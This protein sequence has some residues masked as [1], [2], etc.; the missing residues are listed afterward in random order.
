MYV[1]RF[2]VVAPLPQ[3]VP[4]AYAMAPRT[5][6]TLASRFTNPQPPAQNGTT[7]SQLRIVAF[8]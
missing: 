5:V 7:P 2:T 1:Y 4:L 8:P 3:R 6:P